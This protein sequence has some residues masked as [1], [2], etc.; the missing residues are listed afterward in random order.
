[1]NNNKSKGV[2]VKKLLLH[3]L[4]DYAKS[5]KS[6]ESSRYNYIPINDFFGG[7]GVNQI[8]PMHLKQY[9]QVSR[10]AAE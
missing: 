8:R 5:L 3:Y 2:S 6:Y 9:V 4:E 10:Y 7:F 1:M